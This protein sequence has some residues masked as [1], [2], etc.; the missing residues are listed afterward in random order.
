MVTRRIDDLPDTGMRNRLAALART[1]T[2][3]PRVRAVIDEWCGASATG[4][5]VSHDAATAAL[6]P[7]RGSE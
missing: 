5:E 1:L 6:E 7:A 3:N 4:T 2:S